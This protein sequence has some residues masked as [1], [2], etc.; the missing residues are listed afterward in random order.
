MNRAWAIALSIVVSSAVAQTPSG[1][2][3][4]AASQPAAT[5]PAVGSAAASRT[6]FNQVSEVLDRALATPAA[7]AMPSFYTNSAN[8][9][10][11]LSKEN[12]DP[13]VIAWGGTVSLA[14]T[15]AANTLQV[16]Q[17]R[18][19]SRSN[20]VPAP[21]VYDAN[22]PNAQQR[23]EVDLQNAQQ[24]RR[25]GGLEE[26]AAASERVANLLANLQD[27]RTKMAAAIT[28]RYGAGQSE[29]AK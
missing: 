18:A 2:A 5:Q 11:T 6:Y 7:E 26:H 21:G 14:L 1:I 9:I 10:T 4:P 28:A 22:D 23:G 20:S 15:N 8:K 3:Q 16:G 27:A 12:V 24:A 29:P 25:Q 17:Q 19:E 13:D